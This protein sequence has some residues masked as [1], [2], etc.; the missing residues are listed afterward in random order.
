LFGKALSY[1]LHFQRHWR[2]SGI[3]D[4]ELVFFLLV[5]TSAGSSRITILK[6]HL[7]QSR[8]PLGISDQN[9]E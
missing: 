2:H 3:V 9:A 5:K 7:P 6:K 1:Q 8:I 4:L